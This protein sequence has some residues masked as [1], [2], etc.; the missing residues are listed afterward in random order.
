LQLRENLKGGCRDF[1]PA[2]CKKLAKKFACEAD[3]LINDISI[4]EACPKSCNPQC[5]KRF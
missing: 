1:N 5:E 3:F 2:I 4:L